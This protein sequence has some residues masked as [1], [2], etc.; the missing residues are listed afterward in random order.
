MARFEYYENVISKHHL[1]Q[2]DWK[3]CGS[4]AFLSGLNKADTTIASVKM[5]DNDTVE[6]IKRKDQN[7]GF[8][9][10][11]GWDQLGLY[12]RVIINRK[13]CSVDIDRMDINWWISEPFL[14][15]RDSFYLEDSE[16]AEILAGTKPSKM[17]FVRHNF[18]MF[19]LYKLNTVFMS[20]FSASSYK[21]AFK[22]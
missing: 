12:E 20:N 17:T 18:W 7:K 2:I 10:G 13:N 4:W 16:K 11:W 14:G 3:Q 8:F 19:K 1:K 22:G 21:S 6:I 9:F 5:L 15:Q